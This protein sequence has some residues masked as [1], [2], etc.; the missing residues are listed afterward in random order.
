MHWKIIHFCYVNGI[1][2]YSYISFYCLPKFTAQHTMNML[3]RYIHKC[4]KL[5]TIPVNSGG[6]TDGSGNNGHY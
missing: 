2:T 5:Q 6:M 1:V 4:I 3:Y